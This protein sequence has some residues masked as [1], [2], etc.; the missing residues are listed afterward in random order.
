MCQT[1]KRSIPVVGS[2]FVQRRCSGPTSS[3][4]PKREALGID[5]VG[6]RSSERT[7]LSSDRLPD[8]VPASFLG[9]PR[10]VPSRSHTLEAR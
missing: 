5:A 4:P 3:L 6:P 7:S 1:K 10:L 8:A 2:D 9:L